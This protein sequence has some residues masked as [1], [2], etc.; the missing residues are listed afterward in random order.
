MV[1]GLGDR[2]T[3]AMADLLR[4]PLALSALSRAAGAARTFEAVYA[5]DFAPGR[6]VSRRLLGAW[7]LG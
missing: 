1:A 6:Q 3:A 7:P 2:G 5:I 4:D